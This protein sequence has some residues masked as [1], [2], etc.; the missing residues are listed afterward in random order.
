MFV[1]VIKVSIGHTIKFKTQFYI[2][3][4]K[5]LLVNFKL[6]FKFGQRIWNYVELLVLPN[7]SLGQQARN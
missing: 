2:T 4:I 7:I 6:V 1:M 5:K 3:R